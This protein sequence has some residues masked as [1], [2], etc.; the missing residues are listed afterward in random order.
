MTL[1]GII[2]YII[3]KFSVNTIKIMPRVRKKETESAYVTRCLGDSSM[4]EQ[5]PDQ[6]HRAAVCYGIFKQAHEHKHSKEMSGTSQDGQEYIIKE[7]END[8]WF[9]LF[10]DKKD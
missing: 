2:Y 3:Y 5:Y 7:G 10:E 6:K 8:P 9:L 1:I 4:N